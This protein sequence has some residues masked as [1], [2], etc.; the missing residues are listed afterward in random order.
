MTTSATTPTVEAGNNTNGRCR[1]VAINGYAGDNT[2]GKGRQAA[3]NDY[4]C[5]NTTGRGRQTGC[6]Q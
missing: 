6:H 5:D 1:Q 3:I 4:I 2:N